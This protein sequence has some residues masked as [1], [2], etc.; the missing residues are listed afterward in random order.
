MRRKAIYQAVG[1]SVLFDKMFALVGQEHAT[2]IL[3]EEVHA[4]EEHVARMAHE[5]AGRKSA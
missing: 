1:D 4:L 2:A 5:H 3:A